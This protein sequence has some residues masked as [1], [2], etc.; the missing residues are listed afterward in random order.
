MA[1]EEERL[2]EKVNFRIWGKIGRYALRHWRLILLV[3][4]GMLLTS[5]YDAYLVPMMNAAVIEATS[6][7]G[8]APLDGTSLM[9]VTLQLSLIEGAWEVAIPFWGFLVLEIAA[10][11]VRSCAVFVNFYFSNVLSLYVMT[12]L[13]RDCFR[14]VQELSFSYFDRVN[15]GWLI[16]RM[17]SDTA[18]LGDTLSNQA[19]NGFWSLFDILF[20]LFS[21]FARSWELALLVLCTVPLLMLVLPPLQKALLVRWRTARSAY[22]HFVGWLAEVINGA[23]TIRTLSVEREIGEE[24]ERIV[25]DIERKRFRAS[26][27]NSYLTPTLQLFSSLTTAILVLAGI[28]MIQNGEDMEEMIALS[29]TIVLFVTYVGNI[30]NPLQS[31]SELASEIM[32]AQ[33]GAEKVGQLLDEEP[34]VRDSPEIV[35]KYGTPLSPLPLDGLPRAEGDILFEDVSFHYANGVEV[36]HPLDLHVEKGTSL[37]IVGETGSGKTTLVNLLCR[38]YEPTGGRILLDGVDVRERPL[39]WLH[40][41]IGY[42]QQSPF[43]LT[44]TYFENIAY[45]KEGATLEEVRR[46]ASIAGI[47]GKIMAFPKGYDTLVEDGGSQLSQGEKQLL[48]FARA[49]VR[50][51]K[52]LILDEATSSIDTETEREVQDSLLRILKGRTSISIAHRLSTIVHC[53]RIIVV[54]Q[55]RIVEDGDHRSL[56]ARKDGVYHNLYMTQFQELGLDEQIKAYEEHSGTEE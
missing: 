23:K 46:A 31:L 11:L 21:M 44:G 29:A 34:E 47:D 10:I 6:G 55:G 42:V 45:G 41:E 20:T 33:A 12:D 2:P 50:D 53:D 37:A 17:N 52:I 25:G 38:F 36:I 15:S 16:A 19:L 18:S 43:A 39:H 27:L 51:P 9:D 56:M 3:V 32:S 13:R 28:L 1:L 48:S 7:L 35:R 30:Y 22:S 26:R 24:A 5:F 54:D 8:T 49:L 4:T 40:H 14:K